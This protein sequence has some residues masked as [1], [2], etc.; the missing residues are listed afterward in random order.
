MPAFGPPTWAVL[1]F[2]TLNGGETVAPL[3]LIGAGAAVSDRLL[4][5]LGFRRLRGHVS[6]RQRAKLEA[7]GKMYR[8]RPQTVGGRSG[9]VRAVAAPLAQLF[10]AAGLIGMTLLPLTAAFFAGPLVS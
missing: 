8:S 9:L 5:A 2:F 4:L 10:E 3:V 6:D 1:V 7:A